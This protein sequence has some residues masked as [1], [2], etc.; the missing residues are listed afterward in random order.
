MFAVS[1]K[2][3]PSST[4]YRKIGSAAESSSTHGIRFAG[5]P[6]LMQP[7]A[8]RLTFRPEVPRSVYSMTDFL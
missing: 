7:S 5:S 4:V 2:V 1:Q 8:I 6:K 3:M